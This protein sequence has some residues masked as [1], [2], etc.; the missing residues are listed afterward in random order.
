MRDVTVAV[1]AGGQGTRMGGPK[2]MLTLGG[3]PILEYLLARMA[4][5]GPTMLVLSPGV[6][7]PAG[8]ESFDKRVNDAVAGEG[9]LRGVRTAVENSMTDVVVVTTV[10]M[11]GIARRE[12]EF[13]VAEM[14]KSLGAIGVL[15]RRVVAG[16]EVIEPFP[17][18]YRSAA[19]GILARRLEEGR[20]SVHGLAG[21][22]RVVVIPAPATWEERV[23]SNLNEPG[24]LE[25]FEREM[26]AG[27]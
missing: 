24:D 6:D 4:W 8:A 20:R 23:W 9:P 13:V 5:E 17:S 1:L 7:A 3:K 27:A 16:R 26:G 21:E 14:G 22:D 12:L 11:P 10:D 18:A 15:L 25:R 2:G 19:R